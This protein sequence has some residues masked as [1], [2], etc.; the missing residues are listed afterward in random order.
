MPRR[1]LSKRRTWAIVTALVMGAALAVAGA[2]VAR[3]RVPTE[4]PRVLAPH[5]Q[6]T[7]IDD[8]AAAAEARLAVA[9]IRANL[10]D[11]PT[12]TRNGPHARRL[13]ETLATTLERPAA[14]D[15]DGW[16]D[17][18]ARFDELRRALQTGHPD[19]SAH[20]AGLEAALRAYRP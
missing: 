17:L 15:P 18:R 9:T 20:A 10:I 8:F 5:T 19:L 2:L 16:D 6:L 1:S 12:V 3:T 11:P 7:R 13:A 14:A 4:P